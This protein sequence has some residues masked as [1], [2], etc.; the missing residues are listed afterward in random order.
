MSLLSPN[1]RFALAGTALA[2]ALS[3]VLW[4]AL[5]ATSNA[6]QPVY[7]FPGPGSLSA[8]PKTQL[9][10]RGAIPSAQEIQVT[11][12]STGPHSGVVKAHSDGAGASFI[13]S[14]PFA[15]QETVTVRTPLNI[16]GGSGGI[17]QFNIANPSTRNT[18]W[19]RVTAARAK[20]DIERFRSRPDLAPAAIT[21]NKNSRH[22]ARGDIFLEPEA[23]P[24]Q[25]GPMIRDWRGNLI[26]FKR[27][28]KNQY[29]SDFRV[30]RMDGQSV[31]T[32]WQG[33]VSRG[34]GAGKDLIYDNHYRL[35]AT[36]RAGN[37]MTADL[38]EFLLTSHGTA[39]ITAVY[40]K[41]DPRPRG[42]DRVILDSVV[43]EIDLHTGLVMF[44]WDALD[45]V[46]VSDT[47]Q[48]LPKNLRKPF[49]YF[50]VNSVQELPDGNLLVS[51]RNTRAAYDV[52]IQTGAVLWKLG[53]KHPSFAMGRG[54][55]FAYQHDV[56]LRA[57]DIITMFDDGAGPPQVEKHSHV[58]G[59]RVD[60][61]RMRVTRAF[62]WGHSPPI[63]STFEGD[64]QQLSGGHFFVGWGQDP[65]FTEYNSRGQMIFDAQYVA[66][67][68]Q[69]RAY[70]MR[71]GA[72]PDGPP[73]IAATRSRRTT[74][75]YASWNGA[76]SYAYWRVLA[77]SSSRSLR[78]VKTVGRRGFETAISINRARYVAV[79]ALDSSRRPM[80]VQSR[81]IR[82]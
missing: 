4:L 67:V 60:F 71:W 82:G 78:A 56:R 27:V 16:V 52:S 29:M 32:W 76:T 68:W 80:S 28:P 49:D 58:L 44:E 26:W 36:I 3:L 6:A 59:L 61:S 42:P 63:A 21:I 47:Y 13:P 48:P 75:V 30:Q 11:G 35:M 5:G 50:H 24:L 25:D 39:L 45:H 12:S 17:Y 64:A 66:G 2:T 53:G 81:V 1:R 51:S 46:P 54:T 31:L 43:Q 33:S 55:S 79:M 72:T 77:G 18:Q 57:H 37:G 65:H 7:V 70:R 22:V 62:S 15:P 10:F 74:T 41:W 34:V 19:P 23:G 8:L 14:V 73:A 40:P 20:N 38:H 9:T 69:Y